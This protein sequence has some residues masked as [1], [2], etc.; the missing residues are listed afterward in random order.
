MN[1]KIYMLAA[2][3]SVTAI[4]SSAQ[5]SRL[6]IAPG[7]YLTQDSA[8]NKNLITALNGF[9]VLK[10]SA[11]ENNTYVLPSAYLETSA[12]LDEM[13]DMEKNDKLQNNNF[14]KDY[15]TNVVQLD[16]IHLFIQLANMG[17]NDSMPYL[18]AGF[19]LLAERKGGQFYF[20][21]PLKRN[22]TS[23]QTKTIGSYIFH[24]TTDINIAAAT[25]YANHSAA[26]DNK[27]QMKKQMTDMYCCKDF[28]EVLQLTGI[29]YKSDYNS[30]TY[31]TLSSVT[32]QQ[33]L[34]VSGGSAID[35]FDLHDL[36]HTRL[37]KAVSIDSIN[38]PVDEGCAYLYGGSWG[39]SWQQVLKT[40]KEKLAA[41]PQAD[42]LTLYESFYN[43]SNNRQPPLMATY[44]INALIV[45]QLEKEKGFTAVKELLT[46]G[47]YEKGNAN[48]FKTLEKLTGINKANFNDKVWALIKAS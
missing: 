16:S 27:L 25:E 38:R 20:Y 26:F 19:N 5:T 33:M 24:Y 13:R 23:W 47:K 18:R 39:I 1:V 7:T 31:N 44:V 45:Q 3:L 32:A 40:F 6:I 37:H 29:S 30:Y 22:T 41:N 15:L 46:C 36:W 9:L 2:L 48:Y 12:L 11:N 4:V 43:F 10:D 34:I 14:Y 28:P 21:S 17:V 42:W 35:R 8:V